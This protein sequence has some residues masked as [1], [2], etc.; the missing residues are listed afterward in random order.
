MRSITSRPTELPWTV[1]LLPTVIDSGISVPSSLP[2]PEFTPP[3]AADLSEI[4][5]GSEPPAVLEYFHPDPYLELCACTSRHQLLTLPP[6]AACSQPIAGLVFVNIPTCCVC[7]YPR[8]WYRVLLRERP[9]RSSSPSTTSH[10]FTVAHPAATTTP[11]RFLPAVRP[12]CVRSASLVTT[13]RAHALQV[14]HPSPFNLRQVYI[15]FSVSRTVSAA[16]GFS[17]SECVDDSDRIPIVVQPVGLT[18]ELPSATHGPTPART[19]T[20]RH[21]GRTLLGSPQGLRRRHSTRHSA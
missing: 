1:H 13:D 2:S 6:V 14:R 18:V 7:V 16:I 20:G 3:T 11:S 21:P 5:R 4:P 17:I 12:C 8:P 10:L 9:E 15:S 19:W